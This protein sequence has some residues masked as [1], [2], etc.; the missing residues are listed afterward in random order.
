MWPWLVGFIYRLGR[1]GPFRPPTTGG[2]HTP[3]SGGR[4][5]QVSW[6]GRPGAAKP[7]A[8]APL[9]PLYSGMTGERARDLGFLPPH[10][11]CLAACLGGSPQGEGGEE[12]PS[13][14]PPAAC[15][16]G[17]GRSHYSPRRAG[18]SG[19]LLW[20]ILCPQRWWVSARCR[21][22]ESEDGVCVGGGH[23]SRARMRAAPPHTGCV[24]SI[25]DAR[26]D[27]ASGGRIRGGVAHSQV[28]T[29][30]SAYL[31]RRVPAVPRRS[32]A[33]HLCRRWS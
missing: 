4:S 21:A 22:G 7:P 23:S 20:C 17:I 14:T 10:R 6:V 32:A 1:L 24:G 33:P 8:P 13:A 28:P 3:Q 30:L 5:P 27:A 26:G 31:H 11:T 25:A 15:A 12:P 2:Q 29:T 18:R 19:D 16:V 9:A